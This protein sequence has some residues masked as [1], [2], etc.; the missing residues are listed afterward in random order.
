MLHR[1]LPIVTLAVS[2]L[3]ASQF[4]VLEFSNY[5]FQGFY[6]LVLKI[7]NVDDESC[8]CTLSSKPTKFS[9]INSP[10]DQGVSVHFR[11]PL[12]LSQF[13]FYTSSGFVH[14]DDSS[15][16]WTRQA[17]YDGPLST[18]DNVTFLTNAGTNSTCLGKGLTYAGLDGISKAEN[19]T[20][21]AE[22]TLIN[23]NEEFLIMLNVSCESS[24]FKKDCGVYREGIPAYHGFYGAVKMFLFE[25]KM[26]RETVI[27]NNKTD[28]FD[29]PAIWIL[30]DHIPRTSQYP[31]NANCSCWGTGCGEF[32]VFEALNYTEKDH[33][34][35]TIH[36]YQGSGDIQLG[37]SVPGYIAR[38]TNGI[39]KG[40][41]AFDSKGTAVVWVSNSTSFDATISASNINKWV[42]NEGDSGQKPLLTVTQT[43][44]NIGTGVISSSFSW[45]WMAILLFV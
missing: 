43:A 40:G 24:G 44:A 36:D 6:R 35:S 23:S 13:A 45:L 32:D 28:Y 30:N 15:G 16:D 25:F 1:F 19:P 37:I 7:E 5:G 26:P 18:A 38:N 3:G 20:V 42:S 31:T 34:Y 9:G 2:V 17:Y 8:T 29:L 41:V 27:T 22:N 12:T 4:D 21:L 10:L 33:L 14:G 39:M 11:G